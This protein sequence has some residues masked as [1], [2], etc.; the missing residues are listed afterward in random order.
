LKKSTIIILATFVII[1]ALGYWL[2]DWYTSRPS[3]ENFERIMQEIFAQKDFGGYSRYSSYKQNLCINLPTYPTPDIKT[4]SHKPFTWHLDFIADAEVDER[5]ATQ[6]AQL[7]AL[8]NVGFLEKKQDIADFEDG[9]KVI[10]SYSLTEKGWKAGRFGS[11][12]SCFVYGKSE[13]LGITEFK[14]ALQS[15]KA[16]L[17]TYQ[18]KYKTGIKNK[19]S[20][21]EWARHEEILAAFPDISKQLEGKESMTALTR[22]SGEWTDYY[23]MSRVQSSTNS[24]NH[25]LKKFLAWELLV[26]DPSSW[27]TNAEKIIRYKFELKKNTLQVPNTPP[28]TVE[29][30]KTILSQKHGVGQESPWPIPC[31]ELPGSEKL[32]VDKIMHAS[33]IRQKLSANID[34]TDEQQQVQMKSYI[35]SMDY[36]YTKKRRAKGLNPYNYSVAIFN[37]IERTKYDSVA[38]KTI[39]YLN[40]LEEIG[41]MQKH[42]DLVYGKGKDAENLFSA[43][44]YELSPQYQDLIHPR[45][46][47]CFPLGDNSVEFVD[48]QIG[49][50]ISSVKPNTPVHYKLKVLYKNPPSWMNNPDLLDR[51]DELRNTL[52]KGMACEGTLKID[53]TKRQQAGGNGTCWLAFDSYYENSF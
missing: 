8:T 42:A 34:E 15:S 12:S 19:D 43:Y 14:S 48:I 18:V 2:F 31:L 52:E 3:K 32:R 46:T 30:V 47:E 40:L 45:Y 25:E 7:D 16:G 23:S 9:P 29:E 51:W 36:E 22:G 53:M 10:N 37:D 11:Q 41:I 5:R 21:A 50:M 26:S 6:L 49:E 4:K 38:N 44:I 13:Y 17:E 39:P 35:N 24:Y 27:L 28:V 33:K 20:L 1:S